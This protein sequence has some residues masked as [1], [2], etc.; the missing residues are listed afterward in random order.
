MQLVSMYQY[1]PGT[2]HSE[3]TCDYYTTL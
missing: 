2:M 3:N 1:L